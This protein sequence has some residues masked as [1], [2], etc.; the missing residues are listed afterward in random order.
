[1]VHICD[2]LVSM[3]F[4][5]EFFV[6]L[7]RVDLQKKYLM[8]M[9]KKF[10]YLILGGG[11]AGCTLASRLSKNTNINVALIE[12]GGGG[13]NLFIRM[14]AGNGF[15]FGNSK[16]DWGYN[17]TPQKALH[18]RQIYLPRGKGLGGSSNMNGMIY[19]R[20]V[21]RDYDNWAEMGL[22]GW[23]YNDMLRFF[24]KSE[25]SKYRRDQWH[26]SFGPLA[27]EP[28]RNFGTLEKAFI[29]ASIKAGHMYIDDFNGPFRTGAGRTDSMIKNGIRQSS[30]IAYLSTKPKNLTLFKNCHVKRI[31]IKKDKA[32]GIETVEGTRI[33]SEREVI[34]CQGAFGTPQTLLLSGIGPESHLRDFNIPVHVNLPGFG[35]NLADHVNVS[36]QYG[37]T[38]K[39]LSLA[40]F[41]RLDKAISLLTRW[42]IFKSGPGSGAFFSTIIFHALKDVSL[43]E[44]QIYMTPMIIDENLT[45]KAEET[46]P[47]LERLGKKIFARGRKVAKPG[48]QIDINQMRPKSSGS[49]RLTSTNPLD[50]PL[51][52]LNYYQNK[53]DLKELIEGVKVMRDVMSKN[54]ISKYH[55]GE[56]PPFRNASSDSEI[57]AAIY[58]NTYSGHH[59]C[60]TARM[61]PDT[62][63]LSVLDTNLKVR[64][65][66]N[67]RVCDASAFPTQITG[68][69]NATVIAFAEKAA[70]II[71]AGN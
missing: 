30:N 70:E 13:K 69:L 71:L 45:S 38:R 9:K 53:S 33:Y 28:S 22:D 18:G 32:I 31:L 1:M 20:G 51:I 50:H 2:L 21:K 15:V 35:S 42:L 54:E 34:I 14:P 57:E 6:I 65:I 26:G 67:L 41:Q 59:P 64:G 68:N 44:L 4:A 25:S 49:V 56:L 66:D 61:G 62:D 52:D 39:D 55:S 3:H 27:T 5:K 16:L 48:I 7:Y 24:K 63:Q 17:S 58:K 40:R 12:A 11:S 60:S 23:G 29:E 10:D 8:A 36:I 47:L 37:S 43:P 19:M 46:T